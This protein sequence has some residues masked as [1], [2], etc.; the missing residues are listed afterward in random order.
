MYVS[1]AL[2]YPSPTSPGIPYVVYSD[3][4][5]T[6]KGKAVVKKFTGSAWTT[7]DAAGFSDDDVAD[8]SIDF[9]SSGA[10]YVAYRDGYSADGQA[11]VKRL[12]AGGWETVGDPRFT[13]GNAS[14]LTIALD[15]YDKPYLAFMDG[16]YNGKA[17][18]YAYDS[19]E[20]L[21]RP[22]GSAVANPS[23]TEGLAATPVMTLDRSGRPW[24]AYVD[25]HNATPPTPS[26]QQQT[27]V[28]R[29]DMPDMQPARIT[30]KAAQQPPVYAGWYNTLIDV[31]VKADNPTAHSPYL[32][33][34]L[35]CVD[36][37]NTVVSEDSPDGVKTMQKQFHVQRGPAQHRMPDDQ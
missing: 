33:L 12:G 25:T 13:R 31:T 27:T 24:V 10:P 29:F 37:T 16:S 23:M 26:P 9:D 30:L 20:H 19:L 7:V 11:T 3:Q 35:T 22:N 8:T 1:M 5:V 21:W 14:G 17:S 2:Y 6:L 4:S 32:I 28:K 15:Q 36:G 18:V 34:N